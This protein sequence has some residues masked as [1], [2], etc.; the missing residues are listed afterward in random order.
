VTLVV[1]PTVSWEALDAFR[2]F[3]LH[4]E[5]LAG[6]DGPSYAVGR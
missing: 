1:I 4:T 6:E 3:E 2:R 5:V